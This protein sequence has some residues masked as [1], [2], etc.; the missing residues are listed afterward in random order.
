MTRH[1]PRAHALASPIVV[2]AALVLEACLAVP[3]AHATPP[4]TRLELDVEPL[5][6]AVPGRPTRFA[7]L[8]E[9]LAAGET[10]RILV[11]P[12]ADCTLVS[13]DTL[14]V[15]PAPP[16]GETARFEYAISI[17]SGV[18][19]HVYV[20]AELVTAEGRRITRGK[21]LVLLAGPLL[22]PDAVSRDVP[23]GDGASGVAYDGVV[24]PTQ[25]RPVGP[26]PPGIR[27]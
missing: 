15:V 16:V 12:P 11:R 21:N 24:V 5:T 14:L 22:V 27:R 19:R 9:P 2:L 10:L 26:T 7:V 8:V 1:R 20:R 4:S 23:L 18:R 13:G 3:G 25:G 17:P 6:V